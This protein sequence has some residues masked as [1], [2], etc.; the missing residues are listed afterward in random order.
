MK[1]QELKKKQREFSVIAGLE[2]E[3]STSGIGL[4]W[5]L[6]RSYPPSDSETFSCKISSTVGT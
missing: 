1:D 2:I 3:K 6:G 5:T 4:S